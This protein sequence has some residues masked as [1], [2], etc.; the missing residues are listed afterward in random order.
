[1]LS[2]DSALLGGVQNGAGV[3]Y[4]KEYTE[5][6]KKRTEKRTLS[7]EER[8]AVRYEKAMHWLFEEGNYGKKHLLSRYR[9]RMNLPLETAVSDLREWGILYP[10]DGDRSSKEYER[11]LERNQEIEFEY[12]YHGIIETSNDMFAYIEDYTS[13]GAPFGVSW[14]QVGIDP[15][16]PYEEKVRL[17][18][19][20]LETPAGHQNGDGE[21][22]EYTDTDD[23]PF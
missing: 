21:L 4:R 18:A 12:K 20:Q 8:K 19:E 2:A 17:Y 14:Q 3:Q 22:Y 6:K 16:L 13:G 10:Q 7:K 9:K 5:M 15:S 11:F 23:P 1:M